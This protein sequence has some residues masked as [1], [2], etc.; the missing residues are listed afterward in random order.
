MQLGFAD[1]YFAC[2]TRAASVFVAKVGIANLA[3]AKLAVAKLCVAKLGAAKLVIGGGVLHRF[4]DLRR[5]R[6]S[7]MNMRIG[8]EGD[9]GHRH[10]PHYRRQLRF[11]RRNTQ[12]RRRRLVRTRQNARCVGR[13]V[14][15]LVLVVGHVRRVIMMRVSRTRDPC[16]ATRTVVTRIVVTRIVD[17]RIVPIP[18]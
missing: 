7:S 9:R 5:E 15:R 8:C 17:T 4:V 2:V 13:F 18:R 12:C 1:V 6:P 3:V 14:H 10:G 16:I 11:G